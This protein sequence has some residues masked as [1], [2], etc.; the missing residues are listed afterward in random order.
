MRRALIGGERWGIKHAVSKI[1]IWIKSQIYKIRS[2]Y[3]LTEVIARKE[4]NK[5]TVI[6][7]GRKEDEEDRQDNAWYT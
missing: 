1:S 5:L 3:R 7:L 6:N 4:N 2:L